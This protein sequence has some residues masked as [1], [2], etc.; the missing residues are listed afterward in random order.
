M[1]AVPRPGDPVITPALV[2]EHGLTP[3]EYDILVAML[4]RTP[5]F[6]ELGIVSA[7]WSEHCSYKHSRPL[8]KTL[9]TKA[10]YVLQGPGENAGVIA[11]GD[12]LAVAFKIES[13]NHPS[14]VEPYQGA[15]TGVGGILRDVFTMGAR[16]IALLNS[17]RFGGLD[18]PR[19][20]W[21]VAGVVKGIGDY[22]NCMGVPTVAGEVVFDDAYAGNPLVNA[23]CVGVMREEELIRAVASGVG[24]PIIAVGARTGRDGIHGAS[25]A[26]ED[27]SHESEAKRPR[28]QVGDPFTEKLLLEASLELI[29]SGHIVAIQDMGAAGLTSSSAEMAARGDVGVEIDVTKMPLREE[30][31]TPYE[32]LLSESQERM[33]V[34]AL[35]GRE[36]QVQAILAKWDLAAEVIGEV[37]AEPVYRVK[38]HDR[39]VAEFPGSRLVTDCPMYSPEAR[40]SEVIRALR[41]RDVD[42]IPEKAEESDP[43]WSLERL[44]TSPTIASKAWIVRQYDSTVRA[45]T[46]VGPGPADAAVV[47]LRGTKR[48]L[49]LKTDCNGRYVYLDPRVGGRIAVAEA[50]RN[51]A[52]TG[53]RP[54]AITNCLN[55]GNPK[56]P[57]VFFQFREAVAGMGEAC[58]VLGTPV[59]GGNVSLYNESP[60]G[61]VYP[62]PTIGMVG[63]LE[64]VSHATTAVF[65]TTGNSII[66]LGDN[67]A[68]LGA[69]EYLRWIHGVVAGRPPACDLKAEARLIEALLEAM[70]DG[71]VAS[72]HDCSDGGLAVALAECCVMDEDAPMGATVDLSAWSTLSN[73]ALLFGEAQGRVIVSTP[74]PAAV[75]AIANR[76]LVPAAEIGRVGAPGDPLSISIGMQWF[77]APLSRLGAAY[78]GAIPAMMSKVAVSVD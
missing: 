75:L 29:R 20:R 66:L 10:P 76:H 58:E 5:T 27:L 67:T 50:A 13:H 12:G 72:A 54:M 74:D 45:S 68:E 44:L 56:K 14:A 70:A 35:K 42:S 62:T 40:E 8:L 23:M 52:C 28:V 43:M 55:F 59:T 47:M 51:V 17:L 21:L 18:H 73:R 41:E 36:A 30:G 61:A 31:M 38:E 77:Q 11:V 16:P 39:V 2:A 48:A 49:A 53:G 32:I 26:S 1:S 78:H 9:P 60:T 7:L 34:V 37:I 46:I 15:A 24:N 25:F 22:G 3:G 57:E 19:T 69:S 71:T 65:R 63:L 4:G 33:L 64:D 6:T